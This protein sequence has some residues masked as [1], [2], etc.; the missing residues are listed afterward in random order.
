MLPLFPR[1]FC[2]LLL[3]GRHT[4]LMHQEEGKTRG[5]GL[6][7]LSF[8]CP[9]QEPLC[10]VPALSYHPQYY[11]HLSPFPGYAGPLVMYHLFS[12]L[13]PQAEVTFL[14]PT[15]CR[16]YLE[17]A[18]LTAQGRGTNNHHRVL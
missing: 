11:H 15:Q 10:V 13:G 8:L 4:R 6:C 9:K 17:Y 3:N 2:P 18:A 7:G 1:L 16:G 5:P 14:P 12:P